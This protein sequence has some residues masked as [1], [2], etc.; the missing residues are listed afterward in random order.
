M[1]AR[2]NFPTF[3]SGF[4][5]IRMPV[6][7]RDKKPFVLALVAVAGLLALMGCGSNAASPTA[8][9]SS[10]ITPALRLALGTLDLENTDQA[11][12]AAS[13]AQLLPLW[14]LLEQL[15]TSVSAAPAEI[16]AVI[17]QIES[18]MTES[19]LKAIEAMKLTGSDVAKA[20]PGSGASAAASAATTGS[21]AQ[22]AAA[23]PAL[24][25]DL[26]AGGM[27]LDGGGPMQAPSAQQETSASKSS[28]AASSPSL[29]NQVIQ[30]LESKLQS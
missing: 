16:T 22:A 18:T 25:G 13:A 9:S 7:R 26:G 19:Q 4:H 21:N 14:Q 6:A 5:R 23:D 3:A 8:T 20:S 12:D 29:I 27:P 24:G 30:L 15:D 17:E 10:A 11:V 1:A 28:G 2:I